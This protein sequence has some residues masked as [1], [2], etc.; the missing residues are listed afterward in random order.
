MALRSLGGILFRFSNDMKCGGAT[1]VV[2]L[3]ACE[4]VVKAPNTMSSQER[5][6]Y[7]YPVQMSM[8]TVPLAGLA[9]LPEDKE[10]PSWQLHTCG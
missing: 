3:A 8:P 6:F 4:P 7:V 10:H 2:P 1:H 9:K 5:C